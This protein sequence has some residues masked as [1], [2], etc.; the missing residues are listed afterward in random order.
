MD[1]DDVI[2]DPA[3]VLGEPPPQE[4]P[5]ELKYREV[6]LIRHDHTFPSWAAMVLATS[7]GLSLVLAVT[8]IVQMRQIVRMNRHLISLMAEMGET[9]KDFACQMQELEGLRAEINR[10]RG[11]ATPTSPAFD[12]FAPPDDAPSDESPRE[13][14]TDEGRGEGPVLFHDIPMPHGTLGGF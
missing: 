7:L 5:P 4:P 13:E 6:P 14:P 2:L 9:Q 3:E 12:L 11:P 8:A 1:D 10:L